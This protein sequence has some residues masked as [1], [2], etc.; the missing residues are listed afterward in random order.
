[1]PSLRDAARGRILFGGDYNP[2]QW[3]EEVWEDDVRLMKD[4]GVNS[5]TLGV[6]SWAKI[7]PRPGAREF[8][9]LDRLMDLMHTHDIGVVLATPTA[10]PPPW[11]GAEH[12]ET[13]PRGEDGSVVWYG[14]RQQFCASSP[15][16][17]RYAASLAED[18]AAR[19][20]D[21]PALTVW[22]INNEYCTHCWCDGTAAHFRRWLR[23]RYGTVEALNEAW[24]TAFWSQ[25]YDTWEQILPPRKAQYM[26]NPTQVLDFKRF[27]SDALMECYLAERDIVAGHTPHIPVT[28]NFM[29]LWS[30][31][32]AWAWSAREDIVSVDIYPDPKDPQG[33]QY[34]AMLA[35]MTRSQA[36]G[37]WML[38]EQ[39]AG[40]VNWRGVNH[41][42]PAGLNRLWSLQSV[43]RGAD[44]VCYFQWRQSRQGAEKFHSG[45]VTH[46][47]ENG[48]TFREVKQLGAELATIG[49][50]VSGA[51]VPAEVAILHDW[52]SWWA[53]AQEGRPSRLL[54]YTEI[55]Q[56]WHRA[57]WESGI[58][59]EFAR[60]EADLSRFRMVAVPQLY[61]L[62][63]AAIDNLVTYV[64][65]GGTLV[66]GFFSG[67]ADADD[68]I[69]PG[70][71]DV[72]LRE[73]CGIRTLHE[74]WPL[75]ADT[76]VECDGFRA[77]VWSEEL[78]A[79]PG[80]E[81]VSAYRGGELDGLPAVVRNDRAYYVSTLPEPEALRALL[82]RV[83]TE[84]GARPVLAGLPEGV[85]A[86]R[87]GDLLFLLH[88][89]R[90]SVT[91]PVP[92]AQMDL[93]TGTVVNGSVELG[94]YGVAVL[95]GATP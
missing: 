7:E 60:P 41:P 77:S 65:G 25:R 62:T 75:D 42:K 70:G 89:G 67:I 56:S 58:G 49:A 38:M 35:D 52:D 16:Y 93:L 1:M 95:R 86:V 69:R 66:C 20:A 3:P 80:A 54:D 27:T 24:G 84:A 76:T 51:D 21:H 44:A 15:V 36:A 14:S 18:L 74:W 31:Q 10:S 39:A 92:G 17:R 55:V 5:V 30:G 40:P 68:R 32:D 94:R 88:H 33:A 2:E 63:D 13:L 4:A 71:M 48:R 9:W 78:E 37:P 79:D 6:F 61:L 22:H 19:Y 59:T 81:V 87:R 57:L 83:A 26:K 91:V 11:M 46:A 85:E 90:G 23:S 45:M 34:N 29:P 72:R 28:T 82:G 50:A 47:G 8:G 73:L 43:A 12:P 64:R 53:G